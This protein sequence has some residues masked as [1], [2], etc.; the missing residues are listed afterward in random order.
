[1]ENGST[2]VTVGNPDAVVYVPGIFS[3]LDNFT[4]ED[5]ALSRA[6][7][8]AYD[9]TRWGAGEETAVVA[10]LD[11]DAP[12]SA[13]P[14]EELVPEALW[15]GP[16]EDGAETFNRFVHGLDAAHDDSPRGNT[17]LVGGQG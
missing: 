4:E 8:M 11:Y 3:T 16:V 2:I 12:Q 15:A 1:K 6:D 14:T 17:T 10:W 9:A 5:G 7:S 13:S